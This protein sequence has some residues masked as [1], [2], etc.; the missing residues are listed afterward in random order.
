V[1]I[2]RTVPR[3]SVA[4]QLTGFA[5][6]MA[7][8][9]CESTRACVCVGPPLFA[10]VVLITAAIP[11]PSVIRFWSP[12]LFGQTVLLPKMLYPPEVRPAL[13]SE[14]AELPSLLPARML[15]ENVGVPPNANVPP[16]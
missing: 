1:P 14:G 15:L 8:F 6:S 12:V 2:G 16:A 9:V 5:L 3:W 11:I 13:Q 4:T 10:S 7:G